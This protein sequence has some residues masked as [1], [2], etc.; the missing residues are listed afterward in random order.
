MVCVLIK[1]SC[2]ASYRASRGKGV[3]KGVCFTGFFGFAEIFSKLVFLHI[4]VCPPRTYPVKP[5][6]APTNHSKKRYGH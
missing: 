4:I 6:S 1:F 5:R 2:E 3:K